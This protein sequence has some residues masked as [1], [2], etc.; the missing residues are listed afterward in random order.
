MSD[1]VCPLSQSYR[2]DPK[3]KQVN[4]VTLRMSFNRDQG[5]VQQRIDLILVSIV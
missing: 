2:R 5:Q 1:I 3:Q 4:A